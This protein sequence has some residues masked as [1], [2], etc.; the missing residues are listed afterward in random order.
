M[1]VYPIISV[2]QS[3][4]Y[5]ASRRMA[6][7]W[8]DGKPSHRRIY[9]SAIFVY[10]QNSLAEQNWG[11]W[12]P[13]TGKNIGRKGLNFGRTEWLAPTWIWPSCAYE[14]STKILVAPTADLVREGEGVGSG[15]MP[16]CESSHCVVWREARDEQRAGLQW[17]HVVTPNTRWQRHW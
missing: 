16:R 8:S 12:P 15:K 1:N 9:L 17:L 2:S 13:L 10:G 6:M 3:P 11:T 7:T 14:P 5:Y 4:I